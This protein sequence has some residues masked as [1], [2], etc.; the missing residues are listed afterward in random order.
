LVVWGY[1]R[2][3]LGELVFIDAAAGEGSIVRLPHGEDPTFDENQEAPEEL[4]RR[5]WVVE[6]V[7]SQTVWRMELPVEAHVY[8]HLEAEVRGVL[9]QVK[10]LLADGVPLDDVVLVARDDASYGPT[11]LSVAREYGVPVQAL[12]RVPVSYTRVGYWL[13]LLFEAI[14]GGFPFETT[15]RFL[16]HPLGPGIPSGRWARARKAHPK[17]VSAWEEVGVD[18]SSLAW[19]QEDTRAGWMHRIGD[20]FEAYALAWK[21]RSWPRE[22]DALSAA[23]AAVGWLVRPQRGSCVMGYSCR[24]ETSNLCPRTVEKRARTARSRAALQRCLRDAPLP[25]PSGQRAR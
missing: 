24:H 13:D 7:P 16:A 8:P 23:K 25:D 6:R 17:G 14:I 15:A 4:K 18:L 19:P 20:L 22:V 21:V 12:Y 10:A 1:P 5:G 2:L 11:V 9:A 3:G